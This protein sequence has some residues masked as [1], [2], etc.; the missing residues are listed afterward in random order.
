MDKNNTIELFKNKKYSEFKKVI[1]KQNIVN[2]SETFEEL[3]AD[4]LLLAY[5]MLPKDT[6]ADIFTYLS[7]EEQE[8]IIFSFSDV[9][10]KKLIDE[11]YFD[12]MMDLIEEMPANL[13][14]RILQN[15]KAEDRQMINQF[16]NYPEDS[17]GSIMTIEYVSLKEEMTA[18]QAIEYIR[19]V[20][21]DKETIYTCYITDSGR[22]LKGLVSLR[23]L[24]LSDPKEKLSEIGDFDDILTVKTTD[25]QEVIANNFKKYDLLAMP[26]IDKE[27]RLIGIITI[28]D[29]V[30]VIE[31]ETT[32]DM[33]K[34]AAINPLD[35]EYLS[36]S[37]IEM[38]KKRIPW[39][40]ILMVSGTFTSAI[41]GKYEYSLALIPV[42]NS[43][44]PLLMD[45]A[46][47][48][49]SQTSTLIIRGLSLGTVNL[50][51]YWKVAFK[52][53]RI[54]ITVGAVLST[55]NFLRLY[56]LE[57][58][59]YNRPNKLEVSLVVSF[60]LFFV[61]VLAK[62]IGSLL[63]M[64]AKKMNLDP[65]LMAGPLITTIVDAIALIVYFNIAAVLLLK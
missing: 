8:K 14:K 21:H 60:T 42:L 37:V 16:L 63:P 59:L 6:A 51:D 36:Y 22:K 32:E 1:S 2:I 46:G 26:V 39:L 56:F 57:V 50:K 15:S 58:N 3:E 33:Q 4:E 30:D 28:D 48:S 25:D 5:R 35:E 18:E 52:E 53:L 62:L 7:I 31:E 44:I 9:E 27:E 45:T 11:L 61:V 13:V 12:D 38:S 47:N 10:I 40:V 23:S 20:G 29:I 64:G 55:I 49:G 54:G 65:A 24:I 34:M 19:K 43:F 17:A 41:I